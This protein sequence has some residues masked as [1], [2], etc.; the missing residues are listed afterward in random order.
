MERARVAALVALLAV[1]SLSGAVLA[2]PAPDDTALAAG[3]VTAAVTWPPS[4]DLLLAEIQTG[5]ASASD[6][7]VEITNA[8]GTSVDLAGIEVVYVTSSGGTI[9]RKATWTASQLLD[10]GRHRR[11]LLPPCVRFGRT[12][13]QSHYQR[14]VLPFM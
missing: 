5:G 8:G 10:P 12:R 4:G 7:F 11:P 13:F 14:S 3:P 1:L 2:A 9:T 6:E